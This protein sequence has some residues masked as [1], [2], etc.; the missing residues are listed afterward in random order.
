[1]DNYVQL[2]TAYVKLE[3]QMYL[4]HWDFIKTTVVTNIQEDQAQLGVD[5][6]TWWESLEE[7]YPFVEYPASVIEDWIEFNDEFFTNADPNTATL[8]DYVTAYTAEFNQDDATEM[9]ST[10]L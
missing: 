4:N 8:A 1:M 7:V 3:F 5:F 6:G 2:A 10:M 9:Q